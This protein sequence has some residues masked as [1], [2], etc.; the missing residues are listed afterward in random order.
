MSTTAIYGSLVVWFALSVILIQLAAR[1]IRV[2][3]R[4]TGGKASINVIGAISLSLEVP[5]P[6]AIRGTEEQQARDAQHTDV[7]LKTTTIARREPSKGR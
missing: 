5:P 3:L 4:D 2:M 6:S 1:T 7:Q